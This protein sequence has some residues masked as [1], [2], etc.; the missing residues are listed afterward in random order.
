MIPFIRSHTELMAIT[1]SRDIPVKT[2]KKVSID[3]VKSESLKKI[4]YTNKREKKSILLPDL[5]KVLMSRW[6]SEKE[7][8]S[9][10]INELDYNNQI[11]PTYELTLLARQNKNHQRDVA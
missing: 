11:Q 9:K 10:F 6:R 4:D 2:S 5:P 8:V 3:K 1:K 7:S